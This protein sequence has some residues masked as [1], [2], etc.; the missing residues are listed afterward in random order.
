MNDNCQTTVNAFLEEHDL[1][2]PSENRVLDL[3]AEVGE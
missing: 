3:S 1:E 2:S